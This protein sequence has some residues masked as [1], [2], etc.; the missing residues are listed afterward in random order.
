MAI[1]GRPVYEERFGWDRRTAV[2]VIGC[3][4]FSLGLLLPGLSALVRWTGL[5]CFTLPAVLLTAMA[6]S[7]RTAFRVDAAGV[8]LGGHPLRYRTTTCRVPWRDVRA[9]VL[10][11]HAVGPRTGRVGLLLGSDSTPVTGPVGRAVIGSLVSGAS[12]EVALV[13]RPVCLWR[14][15]PDRLRAVVRL[16]APGVEVVDRSGRR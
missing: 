3:A 2:L 7:R 10:F 4:L 14:I 16:V 5:L 8:L 9:V 1:D 13:S 12:A 6:G 11:D 15:D